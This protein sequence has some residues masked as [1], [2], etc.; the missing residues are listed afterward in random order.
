MVFLDYCIELLS[1]KIILTYIKESQSHLAHFWN[2]KIKLMFEESN[3]EKL[4][5]KEKEAIN[6]ELE[7]YKE[8]LYQKY[9]IK[10]LLNSM[11]IHD[12]LFLSPI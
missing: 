3:T 2:K 9:I 4:I 10:S 5:N 7:K 1:P 12:K 8:F 11:V 6:Y